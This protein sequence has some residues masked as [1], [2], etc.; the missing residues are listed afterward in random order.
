MSVMPEIISTTNISCPLSVTHTADI[1]DMKIS[2]V[3]VDG[4]NATSDTFF[5]TIED[6]GEIASLFQI[7]VYV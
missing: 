4:S 2:Y 3:L 5:F 6:S 7:Y 1:N